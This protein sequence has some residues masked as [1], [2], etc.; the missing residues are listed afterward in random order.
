MST[1]QTGGTP[2]VDPRYTK[3]KER[4]EQIQGLLVHLTVYVVVNAG[5][6]TI[7]ALTGGG[8][9]FFW[10]LLGWGIG[11]AVHAMTVFIPV[12][13]PGWAE[14]RARRQLRSHPR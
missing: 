13:S 1:T 7:D 8:W 6:F 11:L 9:W 4:A 14:E 3:A 5:L 10:P 2:D 12:F